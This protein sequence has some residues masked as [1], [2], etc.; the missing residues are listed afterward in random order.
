[1]TNGNAVAFVV[2]EGIGVLPSN[3][4]VRDVVYI[5]F[6]TTKRYLCHCTLVNLDSCLLFSG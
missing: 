2:E 3:D 4:N 6:A 5:K 1:M